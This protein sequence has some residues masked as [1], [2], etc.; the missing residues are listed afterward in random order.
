MLQCERCGAASKCG[1]LE[2]RRKFRSALGR[3]N[4]RDAFTPQERLGHAAQ[5]CNVPHRLD[6]VEERLSALC[7][8]ECRAVVIPSPAGGERRFDFTDV[9]RGYA[10][11]WRI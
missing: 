7:D 1:K 5:L 2:S 11:C 10:L 8:Q 4:T 6:G 9:R 3:G